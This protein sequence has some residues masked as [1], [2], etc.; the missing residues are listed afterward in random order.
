MKFA[1]TLMFALA[2]LLASPR[3][4]ACGDK[5]LVIGRGVRVFAAQHP[6]SILVYTTVPD[7]GK[8][9]Y[10]VLKK[11]GHKPEF[12]DREDRFDAALSSGKYDLVLVS[13][14]DALILKD[15]IMAAPS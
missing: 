1:F 10:S 3:V 4:Q 5:F 15:K 11:A 9:L 7:V 14:S 13:L 12:V 8:Q 6:T 2:I